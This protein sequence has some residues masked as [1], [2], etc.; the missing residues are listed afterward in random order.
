LFV[1][2]VEFVLF[3]KLKRLNIYF[4]SEN[5][6]N[7]IILKLELKFYDERVLLYVKNTINFYYSFHVF[8]YLISTI[9]VVYNLKVLHPKFCVL[10]IKPFSLQNVII[11]LLLML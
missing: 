9:N 11:C 4:F 10:S 7:F 3:F 8:L 6:S 5:K 1:F 2:Q